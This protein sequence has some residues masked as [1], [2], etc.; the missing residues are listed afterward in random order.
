MSRGDLRGSL[1]H[2]EKAAQGSETRK[3][4]GRLLA[5]VYRRLGEVRKAEQALRRWKHLPN[6]EPWSDPIKEGVIKLAVGKQVRLAYTDQLHR[7]GRYREALEIEE[8]LR[9]RYPGDASILNYLI[10]DL[11]ALG[12]LD[13]AKEVIEI[14]IKKQPNVSRPHYYLGQILFHEAVQL[15]REGSTRRAR[16]GAFLASAECFRRVIQ[17]KQDD[18]DAH[19]NLGYCY[20]RAGDPGRAK[21][22]FRATLRIRPDYTKAHIE[23]AELLIHQGEDPDALLHLQYSIKLALTDDP[24]PFQLLAALLGRAMTWH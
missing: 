9:R 3:V 8:E 2:L 20:K 6:D 14:A 15:E 1:A 12:E 21:E 16:R 7:Q 18:A 24:K 5:T 23:L 22:A 17:I 19:F 11:Y 10:R 4:A 13:R